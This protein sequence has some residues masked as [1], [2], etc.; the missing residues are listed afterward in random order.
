MK[1]HFVNKV[2]LCGK[3]YFPEGQFSM[4]MDPAG[5]EPTTSALQG[6]RSTA[7]LWANYIIMILF[8]KNKRQ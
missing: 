8:F 1:V 6:Q 7:E 5:F 4:K 3:L 2:D